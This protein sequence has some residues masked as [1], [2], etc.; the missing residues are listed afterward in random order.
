ME[1]IIIL[2]NRIRKSIIIIIT[3]ILNNFNRKIKGI[4]NDITI[5]RIIEKQEY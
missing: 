2:R 4:D 3:K 5:Q 1:E